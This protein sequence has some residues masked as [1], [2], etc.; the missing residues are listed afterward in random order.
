MAVVDA[1]AP[2]AARLDV[3]RLREELQLVQ[4]RMRR[5]VGPD[6]PVGAEVR[7]VRRVAEVAAVR[8]V[9]AAALVALPDA[10]V[11]PLPDEPA[12]QRVVRSERGEV[13][14]EAAVRVAHRVRVLA[15]DHRPRVVGLLAAHASIESTLGIH[16]A[17]DVGRR[18]A[19]RS[20]RC[21]IAP[22]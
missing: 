15:E 4:R 22:S 14:G 19:R 12:L 13:V 20:S 8:P 3:H 9:L 1:E 11:D 6:D 18:S 21:L 16:R 5:A 17:D 2:A 10:V 7:V